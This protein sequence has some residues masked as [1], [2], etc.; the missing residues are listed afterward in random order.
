[1]FQKNL[2]TNL[3]IINDVTYKRVKFQYEILY[4]V[5]YIKK[6]KSIE[7]WRFE[8][9]IPSFLCSPEY[10]LFEI[11]ILHVYGIIRWPHHDFF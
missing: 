5:D 11:Q 8:I 4:I 2:K 9:F 6:T 3:D 1:L 7:I 10:F